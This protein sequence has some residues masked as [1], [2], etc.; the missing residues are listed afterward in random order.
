MASEIPFRVDPLSSYWVDDVVVWPFRECV[1]DI[2]KGA[3]RKPNVPRITGDEMRGFKARSS[4][5]IVR[6]AGAAFQT[7]MAASGNDAKTDVL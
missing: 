5:W 4:C 3:S 7:V 2:L 1:I 6:F